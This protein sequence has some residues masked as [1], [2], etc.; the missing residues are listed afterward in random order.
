MF[1]YSDTLEQYLA[2]L[3]GILVNLYMGVKQYQ[4]EE[5]GEPVAKPRRKYETV[6]SLFEKTDAFNERGLALFE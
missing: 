1:S 2:P 4:S 5:S 6:I 3:V